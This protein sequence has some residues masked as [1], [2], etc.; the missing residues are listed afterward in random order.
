MTDLP[1]ITRTAQIGVEV[2]AGG[3]AAADTK[4]RTFQWT[5]SPQ[6]EIRNFRATGDKY[7]TQN[8][9]MREWVDFTCEGILDYGEVIYSLGGIV[10]AGTASVHGTTAAGTAYARTYESNNNSADSPLTY[11]IETGDASRAQIFHYGLFN[12]FEV[13]IEQNVAN[14]S[15]GGFGQA[16]I[17][18]IELTANPDTIEL[19]SVL[20]SHFKV[21]IDDS[22][23]NLGTTELDRAFVATFSLSD[24][25]GMLWPIDSDNGTSFAAHI[26]REPA[27]RF[28][29]TAMADDIGFGTILTN[30]RNGQTRFLRLHAT[31][32]TTV[33]GSNFQFRIDFADQVMSAPS[34]SDLEGAYVAE[35]EFGGVNDATWGKAYSIFV[36]NEVA[37]Y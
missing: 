35:W 29:L 21:Y 4:L 23:A 16:W 5:I 22:S 26:E 15:A 19:N 25:Y 1:M 11:T 30:M 20:P 3:S 10:T 8:D 37:A 34:M 17:D 18:D 24:R 9:L 6:A 12:N 33:G 27:L 14:I 32:G 13:N 28:N 7:G 2:A 31:G 36:V